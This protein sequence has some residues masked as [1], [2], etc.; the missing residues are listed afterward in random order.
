MGA[1]RRRVA[2]R[3]REP[4]HDVSED[5]DW[6]HFL[7]ALAEVGEVT[8]TDA[9]HLVRLVD[10]AGRAREIAVRATPEQWHAYLS[11][12]GYDDEAEAARVVGLL[13]RSGPTTKAL[14]LTDNYE[15]LLVPYVPG[16][17]NGRP[18]EPTPGATGARHPR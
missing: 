6:G 17:L 12:M 14:V 4:T 5:A 8:A 15:V 3:G 13:R 7:L 11:V 2:F 16:H 9:G 1:D 10:E 18:A